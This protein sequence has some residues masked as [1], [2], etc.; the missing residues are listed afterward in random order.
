MDPHN[1]ERIRAI[2]ERYGWTT[3]EGRREP[4]LTENE[5]HNLSVTRGTLTEEDRQVINHHVVATIKL[6]E[7][8]PYPRYLRN[9]PKYAGAHHER[10]DGKGYPRGLKAEDLDTQARIIA[11]ADIF[12]ALTAKDRPYKDGMMLSDAIAILK[13][14]AEDG[15][16]DRDIVDVLIHDKVFLRYA[17]IHLDPAQIDD[18]YLPEC[19]GLYCDV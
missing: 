1:I 16:I 5:I 19:T 8:L 2:A 17:E 14:M 9:V 12:E 7:A 4:I 18:A 3:P 13:G 11:I 10:L 15:Q 6:L